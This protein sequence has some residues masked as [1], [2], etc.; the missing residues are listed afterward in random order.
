[1]IRAE[2]LRFIQCLNQTDVSQDEWR[3]VNII[4]DNLDSIIPLGTGAGRRSKFIVA[5]AFPEFDSVSDQPPSDGSTSVSNDF[6]LRRLEHLTVGPF[7]GFGKQQE[8]DLASDV[9]LVYGANGT[10]KSSFCE[11]LEFA[12]LGQVEESS[13]KRMDQSHYLAN[14]RTASF[15]APILMASFND[16]A[17]EQVFADSDLYRF[18][19]VEKNRI[20]DFSRIASFTPSQ[21]EKLIASL[22]GIS[23]FNEFV[24]NFNE[25]LEPY[26]PQI[27]TDAKALEELEISFVEQRR[28]IESKTETYGN[29][30][31]QEEVLAR[32]YREGMSFAAVV[33]D[34]GSSEGGAIKAIMDQLSQPIQVK[35]GVTSIGM[36]D[37]E[38][39]VRTSWQALSLLQ[40]TRVER[41][42]DLS[43]RK[44]Y[45]SILELQ[46][47]TPDKCPACDTPLLGPNSV[48]SDPQPP[49]GRR[50]VRGDPEKQLLGEGGAPAFV[51]LRRVLDGF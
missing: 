3:L 42:L 8:F 12:L 48:A 5:K 25:N 6:G 16:E 38:K 11:A 17:P 27:T 40:A 41:A 1:M 15:E 10:G 20:D 2:L 23:D 24:N 33:Q 22:F 14:A 34:V 28:I 13:A 18:C 36:F 49:H 21:Q 39:A 29:L 51:L 30:D 43:Y 37:A 32:S 44:L 35:A 9:V 47:L 31:E 50:P 7:R 46:S 4:H 26:I 19:F 45:A